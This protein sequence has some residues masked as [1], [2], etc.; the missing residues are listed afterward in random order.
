M[1]SNIFL[2]QNI[3]HICCSRNKIQKLLEKEKHKKIEQIGI[4]TSPFF[5]LKYTHTN[6]YLH[7]HYMYQYIIQSQ[8]PQ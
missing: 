3:S 8:H 7:T 5:G 4:K 6:I 1:R 2:L